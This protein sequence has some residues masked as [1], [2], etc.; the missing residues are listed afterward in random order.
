MKE[1]NK[2]FGTLDSIF[3]SSEGYTYNDVFKKGALLFTDYS[4]TQFDFAY[5]KKPVIYYQYGDDFHYESEEGYFKYD[6]MG[7][8]SVVSTEED[9]VERIIS[10][11]DNGAQMEDIYKSRVDEFFQYHDTN[12]SKRCY[13]E[14]YKDWILQ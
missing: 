12:N 2:Y 6:T 4:S 14:I 13:D 10:Y 11:I 1:S 8:G 7:F 5:L 3:V 9:L